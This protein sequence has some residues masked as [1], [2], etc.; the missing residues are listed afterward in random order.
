[1]PVT[2]TLKLP[3][4]TESEQD[5]VE[6]REVVVVL[7]AKLAGFKTHERPIE[8]EIVAVKATVPVK[9]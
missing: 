1:M 5:R 7:N 6:V 2:V 8:G 3:E 4:A 9:P